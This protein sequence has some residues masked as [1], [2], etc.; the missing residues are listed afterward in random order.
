MR[1]SNTVYDSEVLIERYCY[2]LDTYL[3]DLKL[4]PSLRLVRWNSTTAKPCNEDT[5]HDIWQQVG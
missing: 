2:V 1:I 3:C 5:S 4:G